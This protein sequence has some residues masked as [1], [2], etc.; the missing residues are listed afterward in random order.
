MS[1]S[2]PHR[3]K[4]KIGLRIR[5]RVHAAWSPIGQRNRRVGWLRGLGIFVVLVLALGLAVNAYAQTFFDSLPSIK[6]LDTAAFAGDTVLYDSG[7]PAHGTLLADIGNHGD[8]RL[9]VKLN[10]IAPT[11]VQATVAI[12]D[13]DFYKNPGFDIYGIIRAFFDNLRAGHI[14]SGASTITQQLAK[15]QFLTPD[16]TIDRKVKELALAYELSQAYSKDQILEL[17]LN[18]SFYGSQSYGVEAAAQ[19]YFHIHASQLDLAQSAMLAGLPQ[20]PTEWNP[21]I[22]PQAAKQRQQEVLQAMVR[23]GYITPADMDKASA[24]QLTYEAPINT[25][26]APHFVD[27]VQQ[28]LAQLGFRAGQ[29]QLIV[30]T[31]LNYS[32]QQQ[33]DQI[34]RDNLQA[35]LYKDRNGQLESA[36]VSVDPKTGDITV[37]VGSTDYNTYGG[38]Y[39][40]TTIP[41]N[42]G[43]ST[44]PYTYGEAINARAAT[45][46]TPIYDG[47]SPFVY[48]D[49][50]GVRTDFT[51]FDLGTHGTMK[52]KQAFMNSLNIPAVK[53]VLSYGP[54][55]LVQYMRNLGVQPRLNGPNNPDGSPTYITDAP[56]DS[57]GPSV[58]LGGYPYTMLEHAEGLA[59]YADNGVYH[60]PEAIQTVTD[61]RG[62]VLYHTNPDARAR[63]AIDPGLAFIMAQV[64]SDNNNR[65]LFPRVNPM[66]IPGHQVAAKTGTGQLYKDVATVGFTPDI[67][68]VIWVGDILD[69][70]HNMD[71]AETSD[72]YFVALPAWHAFMVAALAG[73]PDHWF[74]PPSDVVSGPD[75]SWFFK[76]TTSITHL[77]G[78]AQPTPTPSPVVY[79]NPGDPG[80]QPYPAAV[81]SPSPNPSPGP[82]PPTASP[83]PP[84]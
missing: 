84:H 57:Y 48:T 22:N 40:W 30:T 68:S 13:K 12:E 70:S 28:E 7:G 72:A 67:A 55:N 77:A 29:Q 6:G 80:V 62:N 27:Y 53:T 4:N 25:F 46:D 37:M 60:S 9:A 5:A 45:V 56:L 83:K 69:S 54:S 26:L 74:T 51:N 79:Q 75:N 33:A 24:E 82:P 66:V 39:N 65:T 17:Y 76:D 31:T 8:H 38:K 16:Q 52:L 41:R 43:S 71:Y 2:T 47:P 34:V 73:I 18:K 50:I 81:P 11:M 1:S 20:A 23:S 49:S 15:Q 64:M 19:G 14:V 58:A 42:M 59:V 63:Q 21:V 78:D 36:L 44:K 32:L 3:I 35:N 61:A 10:Q